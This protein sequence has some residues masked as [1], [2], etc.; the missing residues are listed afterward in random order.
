MNISLNLFHLIFL[1]GGIH[2]LLIF[3]AV[4]PKKG[5]SKNRLIFSL[6]LLSISLACLKTAPQ[7]IFPVFWSTFPLPLLFQFAWGPLLLLYTG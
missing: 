5:K 1:L 3:F 4:I 7:E 6:S 2:G